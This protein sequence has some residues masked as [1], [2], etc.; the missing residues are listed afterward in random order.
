[1]H[2]GFNSMYVCWTS[3]RYRKTEIDYEEEDQSVEYRQ[4]EYLMTVVVG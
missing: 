2:Y 4:A 3:N 1:M